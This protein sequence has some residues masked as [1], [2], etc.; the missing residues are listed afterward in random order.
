M[1]KRKDKIILIDADVVSHFIK[2]GE[3]YYINN[4]FPYEI[5]LLD[6]VYKELEKH[7]GKKVH[8]D[9]LINQK[10]LEIIPFPEYNQII[11][12]EYFYIKSKLFKGEGESECLAFA[13]YTNNIIASSN[14]K[15]IKGYCATHSI[16]YLTTLDFLCEAIK[17]GL[18]DI[19]R[20]NSFI[21]NVLSKGSY[22]PV[23]K[24]EDYKCRQLNL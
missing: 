24:I 21:N 3:I 16:V 2:G 13:R 7:V 9:N 1:E 10:V 17:I 5:K 4:I 15:D 18:F 22:L 19:G 8:I 14:T 11:K 12:K 20:C 23:T 6:K